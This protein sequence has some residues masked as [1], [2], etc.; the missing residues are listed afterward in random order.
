MNEIIM[1]FG[2]YKGQ[3]ICNVPSFYLIR[4]Y[5]SNPEKVEQYPG[6]KTFI[7]TRCAGLLS[8]GDPIQ[9][10]L[11]DSFKVS[12]V[13]KEAADKELKRIRKDPRKHQKPVR[14]YKCERCGLYHHTKRL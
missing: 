1:P 4:L 10:T 9:P 13:D 2:K 6:I 5:M 11:C 7:K 14:S 12:F 3:P 8:I